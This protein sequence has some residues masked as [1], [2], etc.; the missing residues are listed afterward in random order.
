MTT[1]ESL[2]AE[3]KHAKSSDD[4]FHIGERLFEELET[5][6]RERVEWERTLVRYRNQIGDLED[7]IIELRKQLDQTAQGGR[8]F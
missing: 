5:A 4:W 1:L 7:K 8:Y 6:E 3:W 2:R